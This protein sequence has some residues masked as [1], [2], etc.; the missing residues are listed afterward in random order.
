[1]FGH[2]HPKAAI[3]SAI[4]DGEPPDRLHGGDVNP[5]AIAPDVIVDMEADNLPKN[6][7]I[8]NITHSNDSVEYALH[9]NSRACN[10]GYAH[11]LSRLL[12]KVRNFEL[13]DFGWM[14][15][16]SQMHFLNKFQ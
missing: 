16:R 1:M 3:N 14:I 7:L 2:R 15:D 13:V 10:A 5:A 11:E 12:S 4:V 6:H 8:A 9:R